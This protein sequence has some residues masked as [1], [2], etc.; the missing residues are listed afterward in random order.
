MYPPL[1][2]RRIPSACWSPP[3]TGPGRAGGASG[4]CRLQAAGRW[5]HK[6]G[7]VWRG[8]WKQGCLK[9]S[10]DNRQDCGKQSTNCNHPPETSRIPSEV[11]HSP[12]P[13]KE[14]GTQGVL[15]WEPTSGSHFDFLN[16]NWGTEGL[17][18]NRGGGSEQRRLT[19]PAGSGSKSTRWALWGPS[20]PT[21]TQHASSSLAI[22]LWWL[23]TA[24]YV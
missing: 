13:T 23:T 15:A 24:A 22:P 11:S 12:L 9:L 1:I 17:V 7:I 6:A 4:P 2:W 8:G 18:E 16:E 3:P 14:R 10:Y 19:S 5:S 21:A 20:S